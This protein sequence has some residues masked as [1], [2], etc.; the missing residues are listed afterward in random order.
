MEFE[1][2]TVFL[3]EYNLGFYKSVIVNDCEARLYNSELD[4]V[5]RFD[6]MQEVDD[7]GIHYLN[8]HK[9]EQTSN[10]YYH[11]SIMAWDVI[12]KALDYHEGGISNKESGVLYNIFKYLLRYPYKGQSKSDLEKVKVYN[13][14]IIEIYG[15]LS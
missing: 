3:D 7:P 11:N 5:I 10:H 2:V 15:N 6:C 9:A 4:K 12:D 1:N 8:F 14:R 13:D